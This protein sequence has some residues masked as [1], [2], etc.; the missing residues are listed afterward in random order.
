MLHL[1][2]LRDDKQLAIEPPER[3][4]K[5]VE[6]LVQ[7]HHA[8]LPRVELQPPYREKLLNRGTD[9]TLDDALGC[10]HNDKVVSVSHDPRPP[11][12]GKQ[13]LEPIQR[14]IGKKGGNDTPL[15]SA[16]FR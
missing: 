10:S 5:E 14:D 1:L 6:P 11:L 15:G 8:G 12:P 3:E 9:R 13:P 2:L 4:T 16:L 7:T